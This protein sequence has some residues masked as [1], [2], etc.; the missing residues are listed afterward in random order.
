MDNPTF[1]DRSPGS[2]IVK[3]WNSVE[4]VEAKNGSDQ[5]FLEL[6]RYINWNSVG[7]M[8]VGSF[9]EE[10]SAKRRNGRSA[11]ISF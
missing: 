11:A 4:E 7:R 10:I 5:A 3:K 9:G 1:G 6:E 8:I 2:K